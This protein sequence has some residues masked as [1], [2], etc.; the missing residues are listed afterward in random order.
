MFRAAPKHRDPQL[1]PWLGVSACLRNTEQRRSQRSGRGTRSVT[2]GTDPGVRTVEAAT[3]TLG[4]PRSLACARASRLCVGHRNGPRQRVK[5]AC[6][7]DCPWSRTNVP[8]RYRFASRYRGTSQVRGLSG[9]FRDRGHRGWGTGSWLGQPNQRPNQTWLRGL[10]PVALAQHAPQPGPTC[11]NWPMLRGC[12]NGC[13]PRKHPLRA[14]LGVA[15]AQ[16]TIGYRPA[17]PRY[18][19]RYRPGVGRYR[20]RLTTGT[21]S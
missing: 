6:E 8:D 4:E 13:D 3:S 9:T 10:M 16:P 18:R 21:G 19:V 17:T 15:G 1:S 5:F 11:Q 7:V 2:R 20:R 14:F 12:G